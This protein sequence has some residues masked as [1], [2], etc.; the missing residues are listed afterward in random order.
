VDQLGD[1]DDAVDRA[2]TIAKIDDATLIE[3]R[4]RYDISNF[5]SMFGQNG[6]AHDIKLDLGTDLPKL[7]VGCLYFLWQMPEE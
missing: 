7:R 4:E 6:Q 2:E 3:Y 5:L 1:F